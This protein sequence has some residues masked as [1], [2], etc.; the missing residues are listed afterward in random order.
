M[1]AA[2]TRMETLGMSDVRRLILLCDWLLGLLF[3]MQDLFRSF[4][5]PRNSSLYSVPFTISFNLA[6]IYMHAIRDGVQAH[7]ACIHSTISPCV[8]ITAV[9]ALE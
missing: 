3:W 5:L 4:A 1:R 2:E 8:F 9:C 7:G 6:F